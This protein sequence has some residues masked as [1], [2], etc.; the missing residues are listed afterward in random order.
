M[1]AI[2]LEN[3]KAAESLEQ[4]KS[5]GVG[6]GAAKKK[7]SNETGATKKKRKNDG[8]TAIGFTV[9]QWHLDALNCIKVLEGKSYS[10]ALRE[11]CEDFFA[12]DQ[13]AHSWRCLNSYILS[14]A[15]RGQSKKRGKPMLDGRA[16]AQHLRFFIEDDILDK[17]NQLT[18]TPCPPSVAEEPPAVLSRSFIMR[19]VIEEYLSKKAILLD[20]DRG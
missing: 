7:G 14:T 12:E 11:A 8:R 19:L 1:S 17:L 5:V 15:D 20:W 6:M 13:S 18:D 3:I 2:N 9:A 10:D 16:M 4:A